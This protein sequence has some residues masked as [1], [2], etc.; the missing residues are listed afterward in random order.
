MEDVSETIAM[1]HVEAANN[2]HKE[3]IKEKRWQ[4]AV[5]AMQAV[6]LKHI[7]VFGNKNLDVMARA[8]F[9]TA[10]AMLRAGGYDAPQD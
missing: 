9:D 3:K 2:K 7:E 5:A 8:S 4:A 1:L 6:L 10:D